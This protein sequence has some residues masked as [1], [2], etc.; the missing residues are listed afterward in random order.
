MRNKSHENI[1][2]DIWCNGGFFI[3]VKTQNNMKHLTDLSLVESYNKTNDSTIMGHSHRV[4]IQVYNYLLLNTKPF[5]MI[6]TY[7]R[8]WC[9]F[10]DKANEVLYISK[11]ID[12][13]HLN[14]AIL[15]LLNLFLKEDQFSSDKQPGRKRKPNE[16]QKED[17]KD[18]SNPKSSKKESSSE[19]SDETKD[20]TEESNLKFNLINITTDD[21]YDGIRERQVIGGGA[22]GTVNKI[23]YNNQ[24][25]AVKC[26]DVYKTS[27][28]HLNELKNEA[29]ILKYLNSKQIEFVPTIY[30]KGIAGIF[31]CIVTSLIEGK[32]IEYDQMSL[33]Q[34][35]TAIN[36]V[37]KLHDIFCLH[38]DIR[39]QNFI[40]RGNEVFIIDFGR[41]EILPETNESKELLRIEMKQLLWDLNYKS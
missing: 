10:I 21:I 26:C 38:R 28:Y 8:S 15:Y 2:G 35:E 36:N 16:N 3:E 40:C 1:K 9:L 13:V 7:Q 29:E 27:D 37:Q 14:Q 39:E 24:Y 32:F 30:F 18:K 5:G 20:N 12:L 25:Y 23:F 33:V 4:I 34:K 19:S 41:S 31:D 22:C 11:E 17:E 6:S